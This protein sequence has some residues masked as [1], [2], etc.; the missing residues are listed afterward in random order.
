MTVFTKN[1]KTTSLVYNNNYYVRHGL[2]F[3]K[4]KLYIGTIKSY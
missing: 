1:R 2:W 4:K 3:G